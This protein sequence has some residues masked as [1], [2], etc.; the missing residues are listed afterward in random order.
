MVAEP[1]ASALDALARVYD[2]K[3]ARSLQA[4]RRVEPARDPLADSFS[5]IA[6][7]YPS[8]ALFHFHAFCHGPTHV[9]VAGSGRRRIGFRKWNPLTGPEVIPPRAFAKKRLS[10]SVRLH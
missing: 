10:P 9:R 6:G 1:E 5:L 7:G 4:A 2:K 3:P 8:A